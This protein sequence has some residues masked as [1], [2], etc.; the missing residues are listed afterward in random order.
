MEVKT[1][2]KGYLYAIR[3][4]NEKENELDRLFD[5]WND[6]DFVTNFLQE[7]KKELLREIWKETP[8]PLLAAIKVVGEA[9]EMEERILEACEN[10]ENGRSPILD[11]LFQ[12]LEGKYSNIYALTPTKA[13]GPVKPSM[14]RMYAIKIESNVYL[15]TGGGIKLADTIQNSPGLKD[16]AIQ[17]I[18]MVRDWLVEQEVENKEDLEYIQKTQ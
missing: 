7:N 5:E 16:C 18:D 1:I 10:I 12:Y 17:Q 14:L 2:Y 13:Y 3:Y 11:D 15:I 4:D 9:Q 6:T 8:T